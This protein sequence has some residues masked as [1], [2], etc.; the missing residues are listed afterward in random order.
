MSQAGKALRATS[1]ALLRDLEAVSTLES[2]KRRLPPDSPRLVEL[3]E[4]IEAIAGR[5][6]AST[7]RQREL[8]EHV[9]GLVEEVHP[10]VP[11]TSIE[12]T[13]REIHVILTEWR[14]LERAA[15]QATPGS[16]E[17]KA[18]ADRA[19]ELREEYGHAH[20]AARARNAGGRPTG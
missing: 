15:A 14:D 4:E 9:E 5:L 1:D 20:E 2:E 19:E 10:D 3:A 12:A 7:V 16:P 17:A 6:L 13:P 8:A 18:A 11:P